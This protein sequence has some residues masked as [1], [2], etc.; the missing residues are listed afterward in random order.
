[1]SEKL[2]PHM[3]K[4]SLLS[5]LLGEIPGEFLDFDADSEHGGDGI[6]LCSECLGTG[7]ITTDD[8]QFTQLCQEVK[9]LRNESFQIQCKKPTGYLKRLNEINDRLIAIA[10]EALGIIKNPIKGCLALR[11]KN[12]LKGEVNE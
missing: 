1:M 2:C 7:K 12:D 9:S 5:N 10:I 6:P 8:S 4:K 3:A 11:L